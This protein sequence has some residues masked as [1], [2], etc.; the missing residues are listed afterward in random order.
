MGWRYLAAGEERIDNIVKTGLNFPSNLNT[1]GWATERDLQL[2]ETEATVKDVADAV[3]VSPG[4]GSPNSL[5][6]IDGVTGQ[7]DPTL[8]PGSTPGASVGIKYHLVVG[9]NITVPADYQYLVA[10]AVII[11]PLATLTL[12]PG[13]QLVIL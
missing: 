12:A 4:A 2:E 8:I 11:D 10:G 13:A 1:R 5:V 3:V 6:R 9:D 7:I